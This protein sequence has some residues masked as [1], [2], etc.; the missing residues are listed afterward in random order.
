MEAARVTMTITVGRKVQFSA[1]IWSS[2][3]ACYNRQI[4]QGDQENERRWLIGIDRM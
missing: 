4:R 3:L 2:L 1:S